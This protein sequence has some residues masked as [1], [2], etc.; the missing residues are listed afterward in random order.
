MK[1]SGPPGGGQTKLQ[2][3][4]VLWWPMYSLIT[5]A[6]DSTPMLGSATTCPFDGSFVPYLSF[7]RSATVQT[8]PESANSSWRTFREL[9]PPGAAYS[10]FSYLRVLSERYLSLSLFLCDLSLSLCLSFSF[11]FSFSLYLQSLQ[12]V[13]LSVFLSI[14]PSLSLSLCRPLSLSLALSLSFCLFLLSV[15][16]SSKR[17]M[18]WGLCRK[19]REQGRVTTG[20]DRMKM[21]RSLGF[22]L[23]G[24]LSR[25]RRWHSNDVE[26][27]ASTVQVARMLAF[28][29]PCACE[30]PVDLP[31]L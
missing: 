26:P 11:S 8:T 20:S 16:Q 6:M 29:S 3:S 31:A 5:L 30:C 7:G 1:V 17:I 4:L 12:S 18:C 23:E 10:S 9:W 27:E 19:V 2:T 21:S 14:H 22:G 15:A 13:Y 25:L 28:F 24:S